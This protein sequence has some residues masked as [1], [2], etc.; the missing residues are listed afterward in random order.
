MIRKW[1]LVLKTKI[2][3]S[4]TMMT[5]K[6]RRS[7]NNLLKKIRRVRMKEKK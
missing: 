2:L 6:K 5:R 7:R 3:V 4:K 1:A